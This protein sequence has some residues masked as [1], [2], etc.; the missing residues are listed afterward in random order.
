MGPARVRVHAL[1]D[2]L[3]VGGAEVL[4]AEYATVAAGSGIDLS[5]GYLRATP[6]DLAGERLRAA[7]IEPELVDIPGRLGPLAFARVRRQIARL[8]PQI[9]HTH[10]GYADLLGAPA[11]RSLGIPV[12]STIHS[13]TWVAGGR[14]GLKIRLMAQARRR[15]ATRVVAVSD[16]ARAAYLGGG[17]D[18]P[19]RVVTVRNGVAGDA[20]PDAGPA[21]RAELGLAGDALVVAMISSLRPEK[22]HAVALGAFG[23][24]RERF[25]RARLVIAGDGPLRDAIARA[26]APLGDGVVLAGYRRDAM[27]LLAAS[28]VL[29]HPSLQDALP[30]TLIEAMAASVPIVATA[31]GGI[32]ELVTDGSEGVLVPAPPE[33]GTVA[34]ALADLL[35]SPARRRAMG[36]A[37][38][39]RFDAEFT[40]QRWAQRMAGLYREVAGLPR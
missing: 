19:H 23:S 9:V 4:L 24:L 37:G 33:P 11:A 7:G 26:A 8:R 32:P 15:C 22:A 29:L 20:R 31:V 16:S 12:V 34:Q 13:H 3:G 1:I 27:A 21:L 39:M 2:T 5:V 40:V 30:T 36:E 6:G 35:A 17:W 28:D 38:R 18:L 10:L 25:P 14:E